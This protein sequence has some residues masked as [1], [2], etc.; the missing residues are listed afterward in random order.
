LSVVA[1]DDGFVV[2][3]DMIICVVIFPNYKR[4]LWIAMS[5]GYVLLISQ[6]IVVRGVFVDGILLASDLQTDT[7]I[8]IDTLRGE[9]DA[10]R[11]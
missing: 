10:A 7:C 4:L 1:V 3:V 11:C 5:D 8:T 9:T 2:D 6:T